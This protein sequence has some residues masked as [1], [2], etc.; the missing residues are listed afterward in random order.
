MF[1]YTYHNIK[2][3]K[4]T[5]TKRYR[6]HNRWLLITDNKNHNK[7]NT[8]TILNRNVEDQLNEKPVPS[9]TYL[10]V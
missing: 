2:K 9:L 8:K 3:K 10:F 4:K 6:L 5:K 7:I 1:N